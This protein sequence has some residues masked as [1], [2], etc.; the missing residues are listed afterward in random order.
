MRVPSSTPGGI[1]TCSVRSRCTV[2][3]PWQ[4]RHGLRITLPWPPQV[5]QVRSIRK[6]PCCARTLP[7]PWQVAQ[8]S[9]ARALSSE[10]V[11]VQA[12]HATRVGTRRFT[13]VPV[14]ASVRSISTAWRMS[15]PAR[16][17]PARRRDGRP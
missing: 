16:A 4:M 11:P 6:K 17:R 7:A 3:A 12:S 15:L 14:K 2:P 13:L 8:V 10:P 1:A 5:G 9:A